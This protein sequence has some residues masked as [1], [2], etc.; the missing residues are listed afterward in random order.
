MGSVLTQY[1]HHHPLAG[2]WDTRVLQHLGLRLGGSSLKPQDN[3]SLPWKT[4]SGHS[5]NTLGHKETA[6]IG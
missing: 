6:P 3:L 2:L 5:L 4:C 1:S